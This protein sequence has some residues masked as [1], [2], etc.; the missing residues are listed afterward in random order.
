MDGYPWKAGLRL[1]ACQVKVILTVRLRSVKGLSGV[2]E[3]IR[4]FSP[5]AARFWS[6]LVLHV[7]CLLPYGLDFWNYLSLL[8]VS[9][10]E[11][12]AAMIL[13]TLLYLFDGL[14]SYQCGR[15]IGR[16]S[17]EFSAKHGGEHERMIVAS[18][19]RLDPRSWMTP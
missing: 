19:P 15:N 1:L 14:S 16:G 4:Y 3:M 17:T 11:I 10:S 13:S 2:L 18:H 7:P 6:W 5:I 9:S 12:N 8:Q